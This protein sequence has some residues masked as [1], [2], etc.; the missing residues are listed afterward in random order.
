MSNVHLLNQYQ[1]NLVYS[2]TPIQIVLMLYDGMIG[3]IEKG[4]VACSDKNYFELNACFLKAQQLIAEL[5]HSLD[6]EKGGEIAQHLYNL[7]E[8]FY[9]Q[10]VLVNLTKDVSQIEPS[11]MMI[12]ELREGW[13]KIEADTRLGELDQIGGQCAS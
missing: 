11:L 3:S 6:M 10:I 12:K 4:K 2:A 9:E 13:A 1:K 8:F 5:I 7:Y